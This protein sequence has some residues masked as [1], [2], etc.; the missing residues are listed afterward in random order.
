MIERLPQSEAHDSQRGHFAWALHN[1]MTENKDI[2]V[3]SMDLGYGMLNNIRDNFPERYIN[4]GAAEQAGMGLAVGLA[5]EGKIP[6]VY[7]ITPFLLYRPFETIR[8]YIH[9]EQIPVKLVGGGRGRDYEHDGPSHWAEEDEKIM[10][11]L[12]NIKAHWPHTKEEMAPMVDLAVSDPRPY[13][14]NLRR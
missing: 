6:F 12:P 4:V 9:N 5:K 3:V 14:I 2:W 11:L 7:S 8:N 1:K 10:D 13:Y